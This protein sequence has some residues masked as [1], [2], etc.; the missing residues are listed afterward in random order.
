VVVG[1]AD[2][3][4]PPDR[5]RELAS[6]IPGGQLHVLDNVAHMSAMEAPIE[7]ADLLGTL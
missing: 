6:G 7:V 5:S 2:V 4:T 3:L 1:S